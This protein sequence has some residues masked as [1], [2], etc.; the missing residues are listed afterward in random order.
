MAA[1]TE[2]TCICDRYR[3]RLS[4]QIRC[5][6]IQSVAGVRLRGVI[7]YGIKSTQQQALD[8]KKYNHVFWPVAHPHSYQ[9][10]AGIFY[11]PTKP[12]HCAAYHAANVLGHRDF[13]EIIGI[14][15]HNEDFFSAHIRLNL[16]YHTRKYTLVSD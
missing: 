10:C 12:P 13:F 3:T 11:I 14:F 5:E 7:I 2:L 1:S 15:V 9:H 16:I 8:K 4:I 6:T